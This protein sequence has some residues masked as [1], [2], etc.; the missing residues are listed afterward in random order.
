MTNQMNIFER[1]TPPTNIPLAEKIRPT[2]LSELIGQEKVINPN[3]LLS[4]MIRKDNISPFIMW[5]PPGTGKTTIAKIIENTTS[6]RFISFS[7]V[8][9]SIKDVKLVM[10]EAEFNL[11]QQNKSTI[12]F[13]DEIHRFN[14][15]QQD[16]FLPFVENGSVILIGATTEN[17]SFELIPALLS[18]CN[19]I[20]LEKLKDNEIEKILKR[21]IQKTEINVDEETINFLIEQAGGDGRKAINNLQ[22]LI[23]NQD[24]DGITIQKAEQ[25]LLKK[26][27]FYDKNKEEHYNVIS[28]LH[29]SLRGSDPQAAL[30]WVARMLEAGENP[31]YVVRRLVRFATEDIGL[32]DPN[33]I[34]QAIAAKDAIHFLGMPESNTV[35]SQ[36]VVYLATAP[37]SNSTYAAYKLAAEDAKQTS[38]LGVPLHIRNAPTKVMKSLGY[39]DGYK[40]D[41]AYDNHYYYQKYFPDLMSEKKYYEPSK[42][43]FEKEIKKRLDWWKKLR[44]QDE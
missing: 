25:I 40:Y 34:V 12:I 43:G 7:A 41:H 32:A 17:P 4:N 2:N 10:K 20:V 14:K 22:I 6:S 9:S 13:I 26:S 5:G 21:A 3:S 28:A 18:R 27:M 1:D 42:F 36:L 38:H 35:L 37:K 23:D 24:S 30:Y 19:L 8:L 33:A 11:Q 44:D 31:M 39:S 15:S 29:K 16:A